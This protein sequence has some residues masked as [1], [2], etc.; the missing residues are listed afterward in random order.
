MPVQTM[1]DIAAIERTDYDTLGDSREDLGLE[2]APT[3]PRSWIE[4]AILLLFSRQFEL[5]DIG[6]TDS[7][8][9]LSGDSISGANLMAAIE[10]DFGVVLPV[11]TLL[12]SPT[13]RSL[14]TLIETALEGKLST[15]CLVSLRQEGKGPPIF[16]VHPMSGDVDY[17]RS[18]ATGIGP[19]RP[20]SGLRAI[21][22]QDGEIPLRSVESIAQRYLSEIRA[23]QP[24]GPYLL[25]GSCGGSIVAYEMAQQLRAA[26]ETVSGLVLLD[27][28]PTVRHLPW[29]AS[30]S[31]QAASS[32]LSAV[33]RFV[34]SQLVA[35]LGVGMTGERRRR[36][37]EKSIDAAVALY[38]PQPYDGDALLVY[39]AEYKD[40][41]LNNELS[42]PSFVA[43]LRIAEGGPVHNTF[44]KTH[45]KQVGEI[46]N[47]FLD[48]VAPID[49]PA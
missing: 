10:R 33:L 26:N 11:S 2:K 37:V 27:P 22:L 39:S 28:P 6:V 8:F 17:A 5:N 19:D 24:T 38:R 29:L 31:L 14:A 3:R 46:I 13:P 16:C 20:I 49:R 9:R 47:D 4:A 12:E 41:L 44:I 43:P 7:F 40:N 18:I 42:F 15:N 23:V 32:R 34:R 21:G 35:G 48:A 36:V 30:S 1:D 25:I 45:L